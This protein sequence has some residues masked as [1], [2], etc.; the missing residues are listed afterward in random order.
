M[1]NDNFTA[2]KGNFTAQKGNFTAQGT[3]VTLY[4][5]VNKQKHPQVCKESIKKTL[6]QFKQQGMIADYILSDNETTLYK[7]K[8]PKKDMFTE[9]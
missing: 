2:Q 3:F 9:K 5:S 7:D 4:K 6:Q 8:T 1:I